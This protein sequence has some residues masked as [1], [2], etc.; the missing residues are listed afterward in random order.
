MRPN[1]TI[2]LGLDNEIE[3]NLNFVLVLMKPESLSETS[4]NQKTPEVVR[5]Q[6]NHGELLLTPSW[7]CGSGSS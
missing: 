7:L 2:V 6:D 5:S 4:Q 1:G 3:L